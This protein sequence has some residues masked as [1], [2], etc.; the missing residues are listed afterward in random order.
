MT[1]QRVVELYARMKAWLGPRGRD[2]LQADACSDKHRSSGRRGQWAVKTY[3]TSQRS[4]HCGQST[5]NRQCRCHLLARLTALVRLAKATTKQSR[6][7]TPGRSS[8]H[9][10]SNVSRDAEAKVVQS[11][12][13]GLQAVSFGAKP[14]KGD[15]P[16]RR[17]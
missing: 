3:G 6:A 5:P 15:H 9:F 11:E 12:S 1:A 14:T 17:R 7:K 10:R 16:C 4:A 8:L 13:P 2:P